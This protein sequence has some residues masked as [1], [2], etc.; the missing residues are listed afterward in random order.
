MIIYNPFEKFDDALSHDYGNK[1]NFQKDHDA[2]SLAEGMNE[3]LL[4]TLLFE[5]NEVIESCEEVINSYDEFM[6]QPSNKV[7]KCIDD[8]IHIGRRIWNVGCFIID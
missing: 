4:F 2:I 1:E 7:D 5:E 3:T 6:E 8:F